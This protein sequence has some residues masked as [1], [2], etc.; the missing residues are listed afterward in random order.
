MRAQLNLDR[1]S[2]GVQGLDL[3]DERHASCLSNSLARCSLGHQC[4]CLGHEPSVAVVVA[5]SGS[6]RARVTVKISP[7]IVFVTDPAVHWA[8]ISDD[9]AGRQASQTIRRIEQT[10]GISCR[11]DICKGGHCGGAALGFRIKRGPLRSRVRN[12]SAP[13]CGGAGLDHRSLHQI[14]QCSDV[15]STHVVRFSAR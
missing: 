14:T 8:S 3:S 10:H 5:P 1:G 15:V 13:L 4:G 6:A 9:T 7:G 12:E 11:R 2:G